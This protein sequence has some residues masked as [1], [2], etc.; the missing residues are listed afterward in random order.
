MPGGSHCVIA[1][2]RER[3]THFARQ[4]DDKKK[5]QEAEINFWIVRREDFVVGIVVV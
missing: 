1:R 2:V 4:E 5:A 3:A